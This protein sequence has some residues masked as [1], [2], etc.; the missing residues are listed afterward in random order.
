MH[1]H[2]GLRV[3]LLGATLLAQSGW[4]AEPPKP[5]AAKDADAAAAYV[6]P[7]D[8][9]T[10]GTWTDKSG[11][12]LAYQAVA[13]TLLVEEK[14][15][16]QLP[17]GTNPKDAPR[18]TMFY[19]AY[20]KHGADAAKRP[21]MFLYNGGP[22][23]AS[24]WLHMGA[25]GPVRVNTA[26]D[27]HTAPAPY[28]LSPNEASLLDVADL[29]FI[30]APGTGFGRLLGKDKEKAFFGVDADARAFGRFVDQFLTQYGRWNSPKYLLGESYGTMRSAALA[31]VLI[32]QHSIDL[33]GVILLSQ[34]L[35]LAHLVDAPQLAPDDTMA[36]VLALP[37]YAAVAW[38]HKALPQQPAAL[39]PWL[40][41]V[42]RFA[43]GE[44]AHAL[45]AG[46]ALGDAELHAV[47]ARMHELTGLPVAYLERARL[48][49]SGPEFSQAL[50]LERGETVG[51]LDARFHGPV[52]DP[53]DR[54]AAYDPLDSGIGAAY[55]AVFNQY[56]RGTLK[57]G[58][59]QPFR[60]GID[61][62]PLWD[63]R[64]QAPGVPIALQPDVIP[65]L[66]LA[67]KL[68]P[69]LHVLNLGGYFDLATPFYSARY[70][71]RQLP[72]P[73][74]LRGN[75]EVIDYPSGHMIYAHRP[76]ALKLHDDIGEFVR[77]TQGGN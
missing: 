22:G 66:A 23:S 5:D 77:R 36:Y 9:V 10:E 8:A 53:L 32:E 19:V 71:L 43:E 69:Q 60:P 33:N 29:V 57:F 4:A 64:H 12:A 39:E 65:D 63:F 45:A 20:F 3:A 47:A 35:N 44:Y 75:I 61:A 70:E 41:G 17:P 76:S 58:E 37:S 72:I 40:D 7:K 56:V 46:N 1:L 38:Y 59:D 18:A 30:D 21:L 2:A 52:I 16:D 67:M 13:G 34:V 68:N 24:L 31:R 54:D 28:R 27:T 73:A 25:F 6:A 26:E 42:I 14:D 50:A 62:W 48:R 51:R 74:S 11:P 49:V 55:V 15:K